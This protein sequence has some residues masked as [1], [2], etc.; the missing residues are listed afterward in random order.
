MATKNRR[1]GEDRQEAETAIQAAAAQATTDPSSQGPKSTAAEKI[2]TI[3]LTEWEYNEL[4]SVY[5]RE[6]VKLST[7]LKTAALWVYQSGYTVTRAGVMD[8]RK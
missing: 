5:A 1:P 7:G 3:R 4:K 2:V 6:G 8:R